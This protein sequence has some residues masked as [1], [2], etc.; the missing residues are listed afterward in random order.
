[1]Q[2]ANGSNNWGN[3]TTLLLGLAAGTAIGLGVALS[4]RQ[5]KNR[6]DS[7]RRVGQRISQQSSEVGD[8]VSD[9]IGRVKVIYEQGR[10]LA[11]DAGE[12][13]SHGRKLTGH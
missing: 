3:S 2:A 12:L 9:I 6:W 10:K 4:R 13:W 1:M 8:A 11:E 5:K 7:A